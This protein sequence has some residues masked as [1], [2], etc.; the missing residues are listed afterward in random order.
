MEL[1][2]LI[3][4]LS[5]AMLC[6]VAVLNLK[7]LSIGLE[8]LLGGVISL[9]TAKKVVVLHGTVVLIGALAKAFEEFEKDKKWNTTGFLIALF[10]SSFTG[11]IFGLVSVSILGATTGDGGVNL[12]T[13]WITSI[14]AYIGPKSLV[15]LKAKAMSVLSLKSESELKAE[16]KK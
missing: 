10:T 9:A 16:E 2:K 15:S 11:M 5:T 14:G 7:S 4:S 12:A 6:L 3:L 13:L 8:T 1:F